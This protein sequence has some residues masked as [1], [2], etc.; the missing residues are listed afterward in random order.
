MT[1]LLEQ[2]ID[3]LRELPQEEQDAAA[4]VLLHTFP[5]TIVT[6]SSSQTKSKK[7]I[8]FAAISVTAPRA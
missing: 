7:F 2:A 1:K 3:Q 8:A 5:A 4:D 6:M